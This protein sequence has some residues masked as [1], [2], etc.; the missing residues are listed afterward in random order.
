M[1]AN[2]TFTTSDQSNDLDF[3]LCY[4]YVCLFFIQHPTSKYDLCSSIRTHEFLILGEHARTT[5]M[6]QKSFLALFSN[7]MKKILLSNRN[8]S[9]TK[10][11]NVS[12]NH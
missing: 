6:Y 12:L 11:K 1:D 8:F 9:D 10:T 4:V 3:H 7:I 2:F 5:R